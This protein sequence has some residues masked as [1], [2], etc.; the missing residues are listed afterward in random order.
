MEDVSINEVDEGITADE[1]ITTADEEENNNR[2]LH[3]Y[4]AGP[5][6]E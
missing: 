1:S 4:V 6:A 3:Y 2:S 5:Q